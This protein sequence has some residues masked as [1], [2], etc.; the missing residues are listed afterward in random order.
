[1][2]RRKVFDSGFKLWLSAA[3]TYDWA[4]DLG[5]TPHGSWPCSTASGHALF[6]EFDSNG[7]LDMDVDGGRTRHEVDGHELTALVT[8]FMK[9]FLPDGHPSDC[10]VN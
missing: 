6:V 5:L 2:A 7:L 3:D 9:G 4:H 8:D 1:M 10:Y